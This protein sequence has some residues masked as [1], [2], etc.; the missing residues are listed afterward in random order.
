MSEVFNYIFTSIEKTD[1]F[2]R[3]QNGVNGR[4]A[5]CVIGLG[6]VAVCQAKKISELDYRLGKVNRDLMQ[7]KAEKLYD[8]ES[9]ETLDG[10]DVTD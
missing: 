2:I 5:F 3:K 10:D 4:L 8:E 9:G 6:I 1:K 7:F